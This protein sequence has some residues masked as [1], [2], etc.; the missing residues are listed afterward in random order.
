MKFGTLQ[1]RVGKL[2]KPRDTLT[3]VRASRLRGKEWASAR[4]RIMTRDRGICQCARCIASGQLRPAHQV[5]H[6]VPLWAGGAEA[7]DNRAAINAK[8]HE[9][10]TAAEAAMRAAGAFDP[11]PW[12]LPVL[13]RLRAAGAD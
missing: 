10:K 8:C 11:A 12:S 3:P 1:P 7:D 4:D 9:A 2:N 13:R 6:V 5:D